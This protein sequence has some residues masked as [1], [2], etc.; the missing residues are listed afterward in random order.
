[1]RVYAT[2]RLGRIRQQLSYTRDTRGYR[3]VGATFPRGL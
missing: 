2:S 3:G 1:M